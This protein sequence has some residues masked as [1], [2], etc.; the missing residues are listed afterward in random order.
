MSFLCKKLT[1]EAN[2]A[3]NKISK[4]YF[5]INHGFLYGLLHDLLHNRPENWRA[6]ITGIPARHKRNV[7]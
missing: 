2:H 7:A 3:K 4:Y 6:H 5:H 1:K